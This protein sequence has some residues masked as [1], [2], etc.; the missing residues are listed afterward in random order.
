MPADRALS[1]RDV[2]QLAVGWG[3]AAAAAPLLTACGLDPSAVRLDDVPTPSP[4]VP[5][6]DD[7]ARFAAVGRVTALR[8]QATS[9]AGSSAGDPAD[10]TSPVA[11]LG[12]AFALDHEAHLAQLGPLPG[13]VPSGSPTPP[14]WPEPAPTD[15][16]DSAEPVTAA[17]L[18]AAEQAGAADLLSRT[19]EVSGPLA[20]LL[21]SVATACAARA[22]AL[23][24]AAGAP[25]PDAVLPPAPPP[26]AAHAPDL[27]GRASL[28][29]LLV[30]HTAARYGYGVLAVRLTDAERDRATA[31]LA[32]H[33]VDAGS[34]T[35]A[36]SEAGIDL[37][38]PAPAFSLPP[39]ADA[40]AARA[41]AARLELDVA[42]AAAAV[43][44]APEDW[45]RSLG[46]AHLVPAGLGAAGW[47]ALPAFPGLPEHA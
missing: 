9:L 35:A 17:L 28:Q 33:D 19:A 37:I 2:L 34:L 20:R 26:P 44:V 32:R 36:A 6:P 47:G 40:A 18:S 42:D 4:P 15:P 24:A 25:A 7:L 10:S 3:G 41:L 27:Q 8:N 38:A 31:A 13:P 46:I 14:G 22:F 29:A 11:T 45:L 23:A 1:R 5:G 12:A 30:A 39:L 43:V 21:A 16:A